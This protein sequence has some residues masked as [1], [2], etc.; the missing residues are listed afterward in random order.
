MMGTNNIPAHGS[1]IKISQASA[2]RLWLSA[3][4]GRSSLSKDSCSSRHDS[5]EIASPGITGGKL[6]LVI[7]HFYLGLFIS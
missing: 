5:R 4:G 2:E 1:L 7:L 6:S 3:C